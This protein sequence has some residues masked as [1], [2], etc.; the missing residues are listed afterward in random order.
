M[1]AGSA[2]R[3]SEP[4]RSVEDLLDCVEAN[5]VDRIAVDGTE[6]RRSQPSDYEAQKAPYSGETRAHAVKASAIADDRR[7]S[8]WFSANPSGEG[9]T[10]DIRMLRSQ[11]G[12]LATLAAVAAL[13]VWVMGD[14][15]D[16]RLAGEIGPFAVTGTKKPRGQPRSMENRLY[17]VSC[18]RCACPSSTPS[19]AR[20]VG[21]HDP[22]APPRG[23]IRPRRPSRRRAHQPP[24]TRPDTRTATP[25]TNDLFSR[26]SWVP[27]PQ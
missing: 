25:R 27:W 23:A 9:R 20:V 24:L 8:L 11:T 18:P 3:V 7:R 4:A 17:T 16:E 2:G 6:T 14:T 13:G 1:R 22:L 5:E 12:L 21:S 26:A 15:A 10:H 19:A